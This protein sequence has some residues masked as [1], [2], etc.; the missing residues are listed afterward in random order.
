MARRVIVGV[1]ALATIGT[2]VMGG[3]TLARALAGGSLAFDFGEVVMFWFCSMLAAWIGIGVHRRR[4]F[5]SFLAVVF[6]LIG[7]LWAG[8]FALVANALEYFDSPWQP[9]PFIVAAVLLTAAAATGLIVGPWDLA[10]S[11]EDAAR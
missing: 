9:I 11:R 5:H 8:F 1:A 6:G 10:R 4:A 2:I 7:A 3:G